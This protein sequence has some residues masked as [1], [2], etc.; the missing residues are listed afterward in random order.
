MIGMDESGA[1]G[2]ITRMDTH[3]HS[4]ASDGPAVAGLSFLRVPE[5][6]SPPE[7]VYD[8]A[9]ARGM[10]LVTITDHDT[11]KGAMELV[12]RGFEGFIPG[13]EVSVYF[14]ED[15]CKLH[16]LVWGISP[17]QD[18]ELSSLGLR[19]DVYAFARWLYEHQ[20]PHS[21]AHPLYLQ[22]GRLTRWHLERCA[23]LFKGFELLNGAHTE[24]H[25][26]PLERFLAG[27]TP[28]R[29]QQLALEHGLA[30]VWPRIWQKGRTAGSDDHGLLNIGRTWTGVR[31]EGGATLRDPRE[32]FRYVMMGRCEAGGVGGHSSLLAH[33]LTTVGA[34][35][36]ADRL[37]ERQSTKGRYVAS[38][39][40]RFA[41]V[42]LP[43]PSRARLAAHLTKRRVLRRRK[44]RG[45]PL[46]E[47]LRDS[48]APLLERYPDLRERLARERWDE[49]S[50]L[51]DH[52]RM[53]Q[54]ADEL[55]AELTRALSGSSIRSLRKRDK[56]G[57]VDH[58]ISYGILL[59]AQA[60]Y[61]FSLFY[62]NKER[63]FVERFEH[64]TAEPGW[65]VSVL[66]RPMRVSLFTD[67]LGDVNG[68]S[69]FVQDVAQRAAATGRDLQVIT[70]TR[71]P[72]PDRPNLFNFDPVF[73]TT[74]PRYQNLEVVFPPLVPILRHIDRHQPDCIHISTPGP[75]GMIGFLAARMLRVPVLG[76]Y[77]TDFPSY[78]DNLFED[79]AFTYACEKFMRFFYRPFW[80]IFTRS[81][82]YVESLA[83][84]GL[85]RERCCA[86]MPGFEAEAFQP[87]FREPALWDRFP[88]MD[89]ASVK[90]LY[91]GR[92]SV[93]KNLPFL[94]AVW[95]QTH[96]RLGEL[97]LNA[98]LVVVGDGPYRERMQHELRKC[99]AHFLGFKRG[100]ELSAIYASSDLFV[101][102]S[103]TDTLG[104]VVM[105]SQG[106]GLPVLVTDQGGPKEVVEHGRTGYVTPT[107]D[108]NAW[109]ERIVGLVAD[110]E[111]RRR[112]GH[113]AHL[114]MQKYSLANS[115]EHFW[116][117]HTWAWH[118]HLASRG[119]TPREPSRAEIP[120]GLWDG[121]GQDQ[122]GDRASPATSA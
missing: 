34:H 51:S 110:D 65:G 22:N 4:W 89:P 12:E 14:P 80:A 105:E 28:G 102:P 5:C 3:C 112:M 54:F 23:L 122:S 99:R 2:A 43:R 88:A 52:E 26:A 120:D 92:V 108:A 96:H 35:Y 94:T 31:A 83:R 106:S 109:V 24:R 91:V 64:E 117:V 77:H 6:Y 48:L 75:V 56:T 46:L 15:R 113:A 86:L 25:R 103:V 107:T 98:E 78:V 118:E 63:E 18:E 111:R 13:Q 39:L 36:Y 42:D 84:L 74:M 71:L 100:Q 79:R 76:V 41:G 53:A 37:A 10:D 30:P 50:A 72:V 104:Q 16:V 47:A 69:R 73:A 20:L 49:G 114:S 93:E 55:T 97:G 119:L 115:F 29:V 8:Q 11:I 101:F 17:K 44:G 27:L 85:A 40:L 67:T 70:S 19:N 61:V 60:P 21:L 9:K 58:A 121:P 7:K 38:K 82:D 95:K 90:V 45:L 32:F 59:A 81:Q 68:V 116:E 33:Q 66:E 57:L 87:R 62:Q 1:G